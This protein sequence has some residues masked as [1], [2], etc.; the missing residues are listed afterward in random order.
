MYLIILIKIISYY[1]YSVYLYFYGLKIFSLFSYL[2]NISLICI[3]HFD[4]TRHYRHPLKR[5]LLCFQTS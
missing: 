4:G 5:G 1:L 3:K 2:K